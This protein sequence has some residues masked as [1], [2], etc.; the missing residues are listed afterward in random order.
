M[1]YPLCGT[2]ITRAQ[3]MFLSDAELALLGSLSECLVVLGLVG[4][5][6]LFFFPEG[7]RI[8]ERSLGVLFTLLT[9]GGVALAWRADSLGRADRDVTPAQQATISKAI[10]QFPAVKFEV[11][12][13]RANREAYSL[14]LKMVEAVKTGSGAMPQFYDQIHSLPRG[15]LFRFSPWDDDL[16]AKFSEV[17]GRRLMEA[18]IVVS[19][20]SSAELPEK[21]VQIFVGQKP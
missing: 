19:S 7:R 1:D 16:R 2:L 20:I 9:A 4:A 14:A 5:V 18:R 15:V 13:S 11:I 8:Q 3:M 21:T 6:S 10:S 17:V 12:T